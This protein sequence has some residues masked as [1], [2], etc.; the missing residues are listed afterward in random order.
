MSSEWEPQ[1]PV[2]AATGYLPTIGKEHDERSFPERPHAT[3]EL[4]MQDAKR[5]ADRWNLP[6]WKRI[7]RRDRP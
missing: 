4:A 6:W 3:S 1:P 5:M 7:L 2:K